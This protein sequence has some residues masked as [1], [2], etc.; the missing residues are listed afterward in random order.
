MYTNSMYMVAYPPYAFGRRCHLQQ[1][2]H[3]GEYDDTISL[4][5]ANYVTAAHDEL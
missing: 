2:R 1:L 5:G 3:R 4:G